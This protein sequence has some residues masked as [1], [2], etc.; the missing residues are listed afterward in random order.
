LVLHGA[1]EA[2]LKRY[3]GYFEA[4]EN[5]GTH[6]SLFR[7]VKIDSLSVHLFIGRGFRGSWAAA[8]AEVAAAPES[9]HPESG[10]GILNPHMPVTGHG[11]GHRFSRR[12]LPCS[13]RPGMV[14]EV[15]QDRRH[16]DREKLASR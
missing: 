6:D 11:T 8:G 9:G 5:A 10:V 4:I 2:G 14:D 12:L 16:A 3:D 1:S 7:G 13:E 15:V